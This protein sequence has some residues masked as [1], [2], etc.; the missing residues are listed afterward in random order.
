MA[1]NSINFLTSSTDQKRATDYIISEVE[2]ERNTLVEK[3]KELS[4][5]HKMANENLKDRNKKILFLEK[6]II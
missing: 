5:K 6:L 4:A 3:Y 2:A 1:N